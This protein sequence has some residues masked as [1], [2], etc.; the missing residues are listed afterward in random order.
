MWLFQ[1]WYINI[2]N[3]LLY[4]RQAIAQQNSLEK[5]L[6]KQCEI[7]L[8]NLF[9][10]TKIPYGHTT[11]LSHTHIPSAQLS[12]SLS[13]SSAIYEVLAFMELVLLCALT[14]NLCFYCH[15]N[16]IESCELS[17]ACTNVAIILRMIQSHDILQRISKSSSEC[18]KKSAV[19][20]LTVAC[21]IIIITKNAIATVEMKNKKTKTRNPNRRVIKCWLCLQNGYTLC[22]VELTVPIFLFS[23]SK[24]SAVNQIRFHFTN[25]TCSIFLLCQHRAN[26]WPISWALRLLA[27]WIPICRIY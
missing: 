6:D 13:L 23:S 11:L 8:C 1:L 17:W 18:R 12:L 16:W 7:F 15:R 10:L 4:Y 22:C 9:L 24:P 27:F 19:P 20:Q 21:V 2:S 14:C 25:K 26:T 3:H 5:V